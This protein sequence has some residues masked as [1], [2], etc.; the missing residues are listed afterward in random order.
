MNSR[1]GEITQ[2]STGEY[3]RIPQSVIYHEL[4]MVA[5]CTNDPNEVSSGVLESKVQKSTTNIINPVINPAINPV[6]HASHIPSPVPVDIQEISLRLEPAIDKSGVTNQTLSLRPIQYAAIDKDTILDLTDSLIRIVSL[7]DQREESGDVGGSEVDKSTAIMESNAMHVAA[8]VAARRISASPGIQHAIGEA[9]TDI[10]PETFQDSATRTD[11]M[12]K[13]AVSPGLV[14]APGGFEFGGM[15]GMNDGVEEPGALKA[16]TIAMHE[17][18]NRPDPPTTSRESASPIP[19]HAVD[20]L[21]VVEPVI[22]FE[23]S[24]ITHDH[25]IAQENSISGTS[26]R[27]TPMPGDAGDMAG[28][29]STIPGS[30]DIPPIATVNHQITYGHTIPQGDSI[31]GRETPQCTAPILGDVSDMAGWGSTTLG[32]RGTQPTPTTGNRLT[33]PQIT[34]GH[35]I[36]QQGSIPGRENPHSETLTSGGVHVG[37]MARRD[38]NIEVATTQKPKISGS[39]DQPPTAVTDPFATTKGTTGPQ[40]TNDYTISKEDTITGRGP[41]HY[42]T[43]M[44]GDVGDMAGRDSSVGVATTQKPIIL[45]NR[46]IQPSIETDPFAASI[47]LTGPQIADDHTLAQVDA[48][49][50]RET[51]YRMLPSPGVRDI[52]RYDNTMPENHDIKP[53]V[54]SS[55]TNRGLAS[56]YPGHN[57]DEWEATEPVTKLETTQSPSTEPATIYHPVLAKVSLGSRDRG[58]MVSESQESAAHNLAAI[59]AQDGIHYNN[60]TESI[61]AADEALGPGHDMDGHKATRQ[62]TNLK[63]TRSTEGIPSPTIPRTRS[64][65]AIAT[66]EALGDTRTAAVKWPKTQKATTME[67]SYPVSKASSTPSVRSAEILENRDFALG[68]RTES[69][70]SLKATDSLDNTVH[71]LPDERWPKTQLSGSSVVNNPVYE[72]TDPENDIPK[73]K[74]IKTATDHGISPAITP[75]H[76]STTAA[77]S[78]L[79]PE[80]GIDAQ[81]VKEGAMKSGITRTADSDF[82]LTTHMKLPI[83]VIPG[84]TEDPENTVEVYEGGKSTIQNSTA[85][86]SHADDNSPRVAATF[87]KLAYLPLGH[88]Q[89][90]PT[91]QIATIQPVPIPDGISSAIGMFAYVSLPYNG[92]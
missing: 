32:N 22:N 91:Y 7:K 15:S 41:P 79:L 45:G 19:E 30:R 87:D 47:R 23:A 16:T 83:H 70:S 29:D 65:D 40:I 5:R 55:T 68:T 8:T 9:A 2:V 71:V 60:L 39:H 76:T 31:S 63:I 14:M 18:T 64:P 33:G 25:S 12:M 13:I 57:I 89:R 80:Q 10:S 92:C 48:I 77:V 26:H 4:E 20:Q 6:I 81:D 74:T 43:F 1:V 61:A 46:D 82:W 54:N 84:V 56:L 38:S 62:P 17:V 90:Q 78:L 66:A 44:S 35:T 75:N 67:T 49:I 88:D 52:I 53:T 58:D 37:D 59:L 24:Q 73:S 72:S 85:E 27:T 28:W 36:A 86:T 42:T 50:G 51:P 34:D 69:T 3:N 21:R 11:N